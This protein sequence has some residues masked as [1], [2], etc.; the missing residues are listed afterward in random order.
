MKTKMTEIN[1]NQGSTLVIAG[2]EFPISNACTLKLSG[3][4]I[5]E[6]YTTEQVEWFGGLILQNYDIE[7]EA[8]LKSCLYPANGY[9]SENYLV[10]DQKV[11]Q[12]NHHT[13]IG[14]HF[15]YLKEN[16]TENLK[17][18]A[19]LHNGFGDGRYTLRFIDGVHFR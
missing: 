4:D 2:Y 11:L 12:I 14:G 8:I 19:F 1:L 17:P 6:H 3:T 7:C 5:S 15:V 9:E 13:E 18:I 16:G 10:N